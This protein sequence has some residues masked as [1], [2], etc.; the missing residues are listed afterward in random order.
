MAASE[1]KID[2]ARILISSLQWPSR[3][4]QRHRKT[5]ILIFKLKGGD[6]MTTYSSATSQVPGSIN[7]DELQKETKLLLALLEDR[8]VG[9]MTWKLFMLKRLRKMHAL[10]SNA[11][12]A[13][14]PDGEPV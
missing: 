4:S 5:L 14:A 1:K 6:A 9:L 8:H 3:L 11:L 12:L 13:D 7:L 2:P 10:I